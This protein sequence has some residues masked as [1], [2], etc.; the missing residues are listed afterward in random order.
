MAK[1]IVVV[2]NFS[3]TI[4]AQFG[5]QHAYNKVTIFGNL[6]NPSDFIQASGASQIV[7]RI[8]YTNRF[9][10][11]LYRWIEPYSYR[12]ENGK[13]YLYARCRLHHKIHKWIPSRITQVTFTET[14]VKFSNPQKI[15]VEIGR[16][17]WT[18]GVKDFTGE[19][20]ARG[21]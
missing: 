17:A 14:G 16:K 18:G 15:T 2:F 20:F 12:V 7:I 3:K 21:I 9:G 6:N 5:D 19:V 11:V 10:R 1:H 8:Q 13:R 4:K